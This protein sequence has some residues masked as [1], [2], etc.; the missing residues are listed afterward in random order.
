MFATIKEEKKF[1]DAVHKALSQGTIVVV[2]KWSPRV[3]REFT[4][5]AF[6]S[7]GFSGEQQIVCHGGWFDRIRLIFNFLIV[8][9]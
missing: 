7:A 1:T 6:E 3:L 4:L 5:D 8:F 9:G 2:K